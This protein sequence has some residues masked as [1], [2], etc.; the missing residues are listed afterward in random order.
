LA[1]Y[2]AETDNRCAD[3][4]NF[5]RSAVISRFAKWEELIPSA[6]SGQFDHELYAAKLFV[7]PA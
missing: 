4:R 3:K 1:Q 7:F 2:P 5:T 6:A